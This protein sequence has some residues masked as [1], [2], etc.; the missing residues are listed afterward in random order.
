MLDA[1]RRYGL[2][3]Q[4][5]LLAAATLI[6]LLGTGVKPNT[7]SAVGPEASSTGGLGTTVSESAA[8]AAN[9]KTVYVYNTKPKPSDGFNNNCHG[10]IW[11]QMGFLGANGEPPTEAGDNVMQGANDVGDVIGRDGNNN[12]NAHRSA[13]GESEA[14][15]LSSGA[16]LADA[17][18]R[19]D[20]SDHLVI[21]KHGTSHT[22][23]PVEEGG[24]RV[25]HEGGNIVLD[26]ETDYAG[27][28]D[29]EGDGGT[30]IGGDPYPLP[31]P[32]A[33][34]GKIKVT[35]YSCWSD[36]DPDGDGDEKSVAQSLRD[37]L[38]EERGEVTGFTGLVIAKMNYNLS[39]PEASVPAALEALRK[40]AGKAGWA[41]GDPAEDDEDGAKT[42]TDADVGKWISSLPLAEQRAKILQTLAAAGINGF[43]VTVTYPEPDPP[44]PSTTG[45]EC[46]DACT[47]EAGCISRFEDASLD[48]PPGSLPGLTII[49]LHQLDATSLPAGPYALDSMALSTGATDDLLVPARVTLPYFDPSATS[50]VYQLGSNG[51]TV[52]V[53]GK[54]VN[55]AAQTITVNISKLGIF[56]AFRPAGPPGPPV[57]GGIAGLL[58]ADDDARSTSTSSDDNLGYLA[59][60]AGVVGATLIA[61]GW[62]ARRRFRHRRI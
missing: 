43:T 9:P 47:T 41:N 14:Y 48:I 37:F 26:G 13:N 16:T 1:L 59:A 28:G 57:I 49:G 21:C 42:P 55:Q 56:A 4:L 45:S 25:R 52:I 40:A 61:G 23:P 10:Y 39:G 19:L 22:H 24:E 44:A 62:Y 6:L 20:D 53:S 7:A 34:E 17:Y 32:P 11:S 2:R 51:W 50:N 18:G 36:T 8:A 29:A 3:Y 54:V 35:L 15:D 46:H 30:G 31:G 27:F 33:G 5:F 58:G 12:A 38:G 60:L